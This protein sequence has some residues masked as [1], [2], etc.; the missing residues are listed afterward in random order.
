METQRAGAEAPALLAA[1]LRGSPGRLLRRAIAQS[2]AWSESAAVLRRRLGRTAKPRPRKTLDP[3]PGCCLQDRAVGASGP[4][5]AGEPGSGRPDP[6]ELRD[7]ASSSRGSLP[8]T[9]ASCHCRPG[10]RRNPRRSCR[11]D[12]LV[13]VAA[14]TPPPRRPLARDGIGKGGRKT[15]RTGTAAE[16][17]LQSAAIL[18]EPELWRHD[19]RNC[20][21]VVPRPRQ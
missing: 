14:G 11:D 18:F 17:L 10:G 2:G 12:I 15:G 8:A 4:W 19:F 3:E 16:A 9:S 1:P 7:I 20:C 21:R 5:F 13:A 6:G